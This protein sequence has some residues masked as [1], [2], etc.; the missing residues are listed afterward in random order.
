MIVLFK[1]LS[2][3][4]TN[5]LL[6]FFL[7][8]I[9]SLPLGLVILFGKRS[10]ISPVRWFINGFIS[11]MRGTPLMLQLMFVYF[12]PFYLFGLP[13]PGRFK[14][15]MVAFVLNYSAYFAE[16][17]RGGLDSIP[18][19]QYE[20]AKVLGLN[21]RQTFMKIILPQVV[22]RV[23]P[24]ITNEVMTLVK[25]T[26]LAMVISVSETFTVAKA[27]AAREASMAPYVAVAIFYYI[28]NYIVGFIMNRLEKN[29][30]YYK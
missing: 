11:V 9:L 6:I 19:G 10:K 27:M 24:S 29:L 4:V 20:A 3:G 28:M 8:L 7:T 14:A 18:E 16:I 2:T 30:E 26:S 22:K 15:V 5:T 13:S 17:Y 21:K 25:D 12:G 1:E 23:L